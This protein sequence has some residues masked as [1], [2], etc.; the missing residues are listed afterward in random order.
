MCGPF[1]S[2]P[3]VG[4]M[5]VVAPAPSGA[6]ISG[7]VRSSI[8]TESGPGSAG[9]DRITAEEDEADQGEARHAAF[10][11]FTQRRSEIGERSEIQRLQAVE[12]GMLAGGRG[13]ARNLARPA[14]AR[15]ASRTSGPRRRR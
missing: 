5:M 12:A 11:G 7:Q 2:V 9:A 14:P 15:A 10:A 4:T 6:L 8:I 13:R 3:P 1:C